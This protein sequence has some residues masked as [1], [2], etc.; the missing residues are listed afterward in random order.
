MRGTVEGGIARGG[1]GSA[2]AGDQKGKGKA[3]SSVVQGPSGGGLPRG[4]SSCRR[5]ATGSGNGGRM[6]TTSGYGPGPT[7]GY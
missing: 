7:S 4:A 5:G 6:H 3:P 1:A 2:A